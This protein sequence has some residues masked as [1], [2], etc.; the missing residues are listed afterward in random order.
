MLDSGKGLKK[1]SE[2]TKDFW[3]D[4]KVK[5][6]TNPSAIEFLR[7]S[8]STYTPSILQ[9]LLKDWKCYQK[10]DIDYL[11][12]ILSDKEIK[13][14]LTPD[15]RADSV[16]TVPDS[17]SA[18]LELNENPPHHKTKEIFVYPLEQKLKF[19]LFRDMILNP[20]ENDAVPYLSEQNDNLRQ[21]FPELMQDVP[22]HFPLASACFGDT[23]DTT[24]GIS[25][26]EALPSSSSTLKKEALEAVN[27]WIGDER[28]QSSLHKDH[29][30]VS[31][32]YLIHL[33]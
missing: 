11:N 25:S 17:D 24:N 26:N 16:I 7:D 13:V 30:E 8:Y 15:G 14:N 3:I 10:W 33:Y 18:E 20:Q 19:S 5:V 28:S 22:S 27:L 9:G 4:P 29:F 6:V 2:L 32:A 21:E 12:E 1:L 23:N 31:Y